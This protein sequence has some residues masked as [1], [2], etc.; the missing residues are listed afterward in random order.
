MLILVPCICLKITQ[1]YHIKCISG[2]KYLVTLTRTDTK[3]FENK[4]INLSINIVP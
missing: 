2:Y 4:A 3:P 1:K